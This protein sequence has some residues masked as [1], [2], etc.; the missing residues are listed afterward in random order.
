MTNPNTSVKESARKE[1]S[2]N[3]NYTAIQ[4]LGFNIEIRSQNSGKSR[5]YLTNG[6]N[7]RISENGTAIFVDFYDNKGQSVNPVISR[8]GSH[9]DSGLKALLDKAKNIDLTEKPAP[10]S[11]KPKLKM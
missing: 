2:A 6:K 1:I 11:K 10:K 8:E 5:A 9:L 3:S 7:E 4:A